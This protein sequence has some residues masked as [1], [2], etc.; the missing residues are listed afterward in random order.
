MM[1]RLPSVP[2][3]GDVVAGKYRV[4]RVLGQGGMGVVVVAEHLT[5]RQPVAVK[6]LLPQAP[7]RAEAVER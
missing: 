2:A 5:L 6:F 1:G 3:V 4:E 7:D